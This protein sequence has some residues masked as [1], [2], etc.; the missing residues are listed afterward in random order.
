MSGAFSG[1]GLSELIP[2]PPTDFW[3]PNLFF[4]TQVTATT[5][6][7]GN[8]LI[9]FPIIIPRTLR[10]KAVAIEQTTSATGEFFRF[11]I[12]N[13][14][15]GLP[16]QLIF[17]SGI[18]SA[19]VANLKSFNFNTTLRGIY[20]GCANATN[21]IST[22]GISTTGNAQLGIFVGDN[23]PSGTSRTNLRKSSSFSSFSANADVDSLSRS[24]GTTPLLWFQGS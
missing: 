11:G 24:G 8:T 7:L 12:Y 21:N 18:V 20:W 22:R 6:L 16:S 5:T 10:I 1:S 2:Q 23:A 15:N 19:D 4:G 13:D 9:Y 14:F 3:I 17:D